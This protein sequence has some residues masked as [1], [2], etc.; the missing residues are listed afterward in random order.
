MLYEML[1]GKHPFSATGAVDLFA[2]HRYEIP[3]PIAVRTPGVVVPEAIEAVARRLLEK[4]PEARFPN[5]R[6]LV[7]ALDAAVRNA[8]VAAPDMKSSHRTR[9]ALISLTAAVIL[10]ASIAA[11]LLGR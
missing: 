11:M 1:A 8:P 9:I 10:A 6:A 2:Q 4:E 7:V 3:A 5:A